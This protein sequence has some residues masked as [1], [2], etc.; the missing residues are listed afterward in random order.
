VVSCRTSRLAEAPFK[1]D[2]NPFKAP[3]SLALSPLRRERVFGVQCSASFGLLR[4]L[5]DIPEP[6]TDRDVGVPKKARHGFR[7]NALTL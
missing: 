2:L 7:F 6:L 3:L 5:F 1:S 4:K